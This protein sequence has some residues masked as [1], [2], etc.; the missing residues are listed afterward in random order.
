MK[1]LKRQLQQTKMVASLAPFHLLTACSLWLR[2]CNVWSF[3]VSAIFAA[4]LES[5]S[6]E[7]LLFVRNFRLRS[8]RRLHFR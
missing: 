6:R 1:T 3:C 2:F 4:K 5:F 8:E 7:R